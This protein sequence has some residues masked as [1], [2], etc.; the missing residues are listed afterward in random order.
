MATAVRRVSWAELLAHPEVS[1]RAVEAGPIGLMAFHGGLEAGT[2]EIAVAA[3][4][5]AGCSLYVVSQPSWLR[6]HVP[7]HRVDPDGSAALAGW[8][9][10]VRLA[11]ALHGYARPG[12][13]RRVLVGGR[14]RTAA[15]VV[16][17]HLAARLPDLQVVTDLADIPPELRGLHPANPVN[18]PEF[19]G[20]QIE[21][22][23]TAR[24]ARLAPGAPRKVAA[25]LAAAISELQP[26]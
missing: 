24:D 13:P 14:A 3:A 20:V 11:V 25:A 26:G 10:H 8:L 21:L 5:G 23:P 12:R 7:S 22:P 17:H 19:G 15:I 16:G 18:R 1:E 2:A 6:W 9:A 4:A